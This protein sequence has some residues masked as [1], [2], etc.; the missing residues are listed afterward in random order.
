MVLNFRVTQ[1]NQF[2]IFII[3]T[4]LYKEVKGGVTCSNKVANKKLVIHNRIRVTIMLVSRNYYSM[5]LC[6]YK[7]R[8]F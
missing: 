2:K 6:F 3:E 5:L 8:I 7:Y 4:T 1:L